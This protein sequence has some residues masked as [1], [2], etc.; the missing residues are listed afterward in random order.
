MSFLSGDAS[1][2]EESRS[3]PFE[4]SSPGPTP[5][6]VDEARALGRRLWREALE[7]A[8]APAR[9]LDDRRLYWSRLAASRAI[10]QAHAPA[11]ADPLILALDHA[12]R[13]YDED[14]EEPDA[15]HLLISGFD[16]F[17]LDPDDASP[18]ARGRANPS[19]AALLALCG[20]TLEVGGLR[21]ELR[22][23]IFPVRYAD[24]DAGVVEA[25]FGPRLL[26]RPALLMTISQGRGEDFAVEQWAGRRRSA[27]TPDNARVLCGGS[28]HAP[29]DPVGLAEGPEFIPTTLPSRA[30]WSTLGRAG[31]TIDERAL[32][33]LARPGAAPA[34]RERPSPGA[35]SVAGS[36]GGYLSN[37]IFYRVS[38]LRRALAPD[39]P[40]GH[41]HTPYLPPPLPGAPDEGFE[42]LRARIVDD[43]ER[44]L[45]DLLPVLA[46]GA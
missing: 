11:E 9:D 27:S 3:A 10:R 24:F 14:F 37:E 17:R 19:G 44:I 5:R 23:A 6:T 41:L 7:R 38:R 18:G 26:A 36:G 31:P 32:L 15:L 20:R 1:R 25:F 40:Q 4:V 45:R 30:I 46:Q 13:G 21:A 42:A 35:L 8:Q 12:S 29:V 28:E 16:P 34:W 39:L 33:E 22:G 43:V 2:V